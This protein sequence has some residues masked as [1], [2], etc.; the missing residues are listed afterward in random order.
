MDAVPRE[1]KRWS[2]SAYDFLVA[3]GA[4][5]P[6][7][8]VELIE[9][10]ILT[11]PPQNRPHATT[12]MLTQEA[13]RQAFGPQ[14]HVQVQLPLAISHVSE[15]EPD[16][17]VIAGSPRDYP[18]HPTTARL[19]VEV[20]DTTLAFDRKRKG[21]LYAGAGIP[22]Y[23]IVNLADRILE[24]YREPIETADGW[25]YRLVHRVG[26]GEQVIPLG[27]AAGIRID[28]LLP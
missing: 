7:E 15:P 10:D 24:V 14:C 4:F 3:Q 13:L 1:P 19:V 9:G 6:N 17:A 16:L 25:H 27:Q 11:M 12:V 20:S 28:A 18:Q 5:Q 26:P 22:E 8:R 21:P 23:W 2:R